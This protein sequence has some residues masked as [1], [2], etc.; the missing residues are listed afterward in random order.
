MK[1]AKS[2]HVIRVDSNARSVGDAPDIGQVVRVRGLARSSV[3]SLTDGRRRKRKAGVSS[4][5]RIARNDHRRLVRSSTFVFGALTFVCVIAALGIWLSSQRN[6]SDV[7]TTLS[8][9]ASEQRVRVIS[10]FQS[11]SEQDAVATVKQALA[12]RTA[13][14]IEDYFRLGNSSREEVLEFLQGLEAENGEVREFKWLSSIDAN[15]LSVDGVQVSFSREGKRS[16]RVALLT[17]DVSGKWKV[18]FDGFARTSKLSWDNFL[19]Q[20]MTSI[21]VRAYI[22]KDMYYNGPFSDEGQWLCYGIVSPDR[23]ESL[24]G[25]CKIGSVQAAALDAILVKQ[26]KLPRVTLEISRAEGADPRQVMISSV[27]GEDWILGHVPFEERFK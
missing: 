2:K 4:R 1:P 25:Y 19:N 9:E 3:S 22:A 24:F 13:G 6:D 5:N 10:K 17:P 14:P 20:S 16:V 7:P 8:T 12:V 27:L 21:Q 18:D 23:E 11:P 15:G 26:T